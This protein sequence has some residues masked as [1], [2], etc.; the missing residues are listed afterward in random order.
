MDA[1]TTRRPGVQEAGD[2]PAR[3]FA[4]NERQLAVWFLLPSI[5]YVVVQLLNV[6]F[7]LAHNIPRRTRSSRTYSGSQSD[8]EYP[9]PR[10]A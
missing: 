2:R 10:S 4:D 1:A 7:R 8:H 5:L 3:R 9:R 6:G